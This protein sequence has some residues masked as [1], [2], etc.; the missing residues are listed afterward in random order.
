MCQDLAAPLPATDLPS[1]PR[2][3]PGN[4]RICL[5]RLFNSPSYRIY[6]VSGRILALA[7]LLYGW[8]VLGLVWALAWTA[9][10]E[11]LCHFSTVPSKTSRPYHMY[12][13]ASDA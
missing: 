12:L 6:L 10:Y 5:V 1:Y 11:R 7:R 13:G 2:T 9:S 4:V 8:C 3:I